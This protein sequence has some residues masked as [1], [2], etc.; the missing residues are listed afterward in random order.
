MVGRE[1]AKAGRVQ[2]VS[3]NPLGEFNSRH[4]HNA[5]GQKSPNPLGQNKDGD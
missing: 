5:F 2:G 1:P 4:G 3:R